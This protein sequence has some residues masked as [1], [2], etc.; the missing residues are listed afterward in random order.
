MV[1][2]IT[3][4]QSP[5]GIAWQGDVGVVQYGAGDAGMVVIFYNKAQ[6][7]PAKSATEGRPIYED[8][9]FV[10]IH[11]PGER[12]NVIDRPAT[13]DDRRRW[14]MQWHQFTQQKQQVPEGTPVDLL[15]PEHPSIPAMLRAYHVHTVEHLAQLSG[16][17]IDNLGMGAQ[18]YVNDARRFLDQAEK[19]KGS[20]ATRKQI[21]ELEGKL[22]VAQGQVEQLKGIVAAL[23]N[24][25]ASMP[26]LAQVQQML[27]AVMQVPAQA[28]QIDG[29]AHMINNLHPTAE[30]AKVEPAKRKRPALK[31]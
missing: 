16:N 31:R 15:Y 30:I 9:V 29:Q 22:R 5:T 28:P 12:L 13:D 24:A 3:E 10:K 11:A 18:R 19:G 6:H 7:S 17:A 4:F 21:E 14:P 23:Q 27:S 20:T 1:G 26:N 25:Q 8:S 2:E